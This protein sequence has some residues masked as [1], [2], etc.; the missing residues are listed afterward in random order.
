MTML[1]SSGDRYVIRLRRELG[2]P[3]LPGG[4]EREA[5][6]G[7]GVAW[8]GLGCEGAGPLPRAA[9]IPRLQSSL[10]WIDRRRMAFLI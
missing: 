7:S 8:V 9:L 3:S 2:R 5:R 6:E 1:A 10:D 4:G